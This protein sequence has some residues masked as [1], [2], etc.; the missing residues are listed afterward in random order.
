MIKNSLVAVVLALSGLCTGV[1]AQ[2]F[3]EIDD[4]VF[5]GMERGVYPGAV[6]V[7][8]RRDSILYARG[9]GHFTWLFFD[10]LVWEHGA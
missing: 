7:I 10:S 6:V 9:Y 4:A 5:Q 3:T 2:G 8:G 1:S